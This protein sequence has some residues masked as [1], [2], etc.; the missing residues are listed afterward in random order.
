MNKNV[1]CM[2][3]V[4]HEQNRLHI[5]W[6]TLIT[7]ENYDKFVLVDV[8]N[9]Q[10]TTEGILYNENNI[11][12]NLNFPH[13]VSKR[14]YW[15]SY[16]NRNVI[17]FYAHLRMLN[18]YIQNPNYEYYWFFDDDVRIDNWSDFL[19]S[20]DD[21]KSD[22]ISYFIFKK[23]NVESQPNIPIIDERT[24]SKHMWFERFPGD[25]DTLPQDIT[26]Y[27]GSFFPTTRYSNSAMKKLL[28]INNSGYFGYGEG[29]VPTI[30]NY[31]GMSL[32]TLI[33]SDNTSDLFDN[34]N[35]KVYHKN[36]IIDWEWI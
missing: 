10:S 17:W 23:H 6:P 12:L 2:C 21:D 13:E 7:N 25:T 20:V 28:E 19:K 26:E 15:N 3:T 14:H 1:A 4:S 36:I 5:E 16:G 11:R 31:F 34:N 22:F 35:N 29:F 8:T 9:N 18:F 30:L 24:T 33:K 32:N 27:F